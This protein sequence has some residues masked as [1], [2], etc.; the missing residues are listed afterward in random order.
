MQPRKPAKV[1]HVPPDSTSISCQRITV[2]LCDV[3]EALLLDAF[4]YTPIIMFMAKI[5]PG[6]TQSPT[7]YCILV[8]TTEQH[9]TVNVLLSTS[10]Y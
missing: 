5:F 7:Y 2:Q 10:C 9:C 1:L 8:F 4:T 3:K 6:H